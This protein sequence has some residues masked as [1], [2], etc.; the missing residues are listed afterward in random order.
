ME[1]DAER[2]SAQVA[3]DTA[4]V[5]ETVD[6]V[7]IDLDRE[8]GPAIDLTRLYRLWEANNWSAYALDFTQD[9]R[10]WRERLTPLQRRAAEWNYALF[11]HGEEAVARTLAPFVSAAYT[12]EQRI[13]LTTQIVDEARHHVF[14]SRFMR[15]V[16]GVGHDMQSTLE[17]VRPDLT[18]GFRRVFDQLDRLTD[19]LRRHP[20]D[21]VLL[22][23][24][25][26]LYHLVIEGTLA[27][28][29]Q[30]MI[31]AYV[32]TMGMLPGFAQGIASVSR[33]ES[34][35]MAFGVQVL[36]EL[37]AASAATKRAVIHLLNRILPWTLSL[38][39]SQ[40]LGDDAVRVFGWELEDL[41]AFGLRS[42]DTKLK[43]AGIQPGEVATLVKIGGDGTPPD[44]ARRALKL[45][46]AGVFG[47]AA[48]LRVDDEIL[49][50][51][52]EGLQDVMNM[53][54][55]SNVPGAIQWDF[56]DAPP[57]YVEPAADRVYAC[58]GRADAPVLTLRCSVDDWARIAGDKLNP[59]LALVTRKLKLSGESKLMLRLPA[60]LG[61]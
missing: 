30:H 12:Q 38:F 4:G 36:G 10:D 1:Y 29:G 49:T 9:A 44:R 45:L 3:V 16:I 8:T 53:R 13:F 48:P 60:I 15:E 50:M 57:W 54:P 35:H 6:E 42:F 52:F 51:L 26:A 39:I 22:A 37:V 24:C 14:F 61:S 33:D 46:R 40:E 18:I 58:Q 56:T 19:R 7:G 31:R 25:I 43:R 27:H 32:T 20:T 34:R 11:L 28:P 21:R 41:Y 2:L 17:A 23:Q 47:S 59:T 55:P 5:A